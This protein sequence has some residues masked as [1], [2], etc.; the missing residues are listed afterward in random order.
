MNTDLQTV[1]FCK[2]SMHTALQ[3]SPVT[4][5]DIPHLGAL[6]PDDWP[7]IRAQ[8]A[9][10]LQSPVSYP[11]KGML[12]NTIA[13]VG[14]IITYV[15]TAWLAH[16]IVRPE[17]RSR[18]YGTQVTEALMQL[19]GSRG[20]R[21]ISLIA[22]AAG[23]ALYNK[24][25][26]ATEA[27]YCFYRRSYSTK[28]EFGNVPNCLRSKRKHYAQILQLDKLASGEDRAAVLTPFL[29]DSW[30]YNPK[31]EVEGFYLP[32]LGEGVVVAAHQKAGYALAQ[33]RLGTSHISVVPKQNKPICSF[34]EGHGF[35]IYRSASRMRKG[36]PLAWKPE[37][38]YNRI[39]G[40]LG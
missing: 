8:F 30:I 21:T 27:T 11:Y 24:L 4:P 31:D 29:Q 6:Q 23:K 14:C 40:N 16:I 39:G 38:M 2:R 9:W 37:M 34:L 28:V 1:A 33:L 7:D 25:G 13:A 32:A 36:A 22:T 17:L 15:H 20:Y 10:Y 26:F 35:T 19:E 18:G 3:L 5:D 12:G